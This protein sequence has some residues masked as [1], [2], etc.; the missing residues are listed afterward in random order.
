MEKNDVQWIV[1]V[2]IMDPQGVVDWLKDPRNVESVSLTYLRVVAQVLSHPTVAGDARH[3]SVF[4]TCV[5][6]IVRRRHTEEYDEENQM[7]IDLLNVL[8]LD[9]LVDKSS[10]NADNISTDFIVVLLEHLPRNDV[11]E[12]LLLW[13]GVKQN[14]GTLIRRILDADRRRQRRERERG[15]ERERGRGI[16]LGRLP[17]AQAVAQKRYDIALAFFDAATESGTYVHAHFQQVV[18]RHFDM[19]PYDFCMEEQAKDVRAI[20]QNAVDDDK[21]EG[22]GCRTHA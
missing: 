14:N 8:M 21:E 1:T 4:E 20:L 13:K 19:Y 16:H 3:L 2:L 12:E 7:T 15:G 18:V 5:K 6:E 17:F 22:R 9:R 10:D 11:S